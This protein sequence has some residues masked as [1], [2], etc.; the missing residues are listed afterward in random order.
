MLGLKSRVRISAE[1]EEKIVKLAL[2]NSYDK[3]SNY[4]DEFTVSTI[5]HTAWRNIMLRVSNSIYIEHE[6]TEFDT[7]LKKIKKIKSGF[8]ERGSDIHLSI[9]PI[10]K[11]DKF[12]RKYNKKRIVA[13]II[14]KPHNG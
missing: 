8:K 7:I 9:A 14:G 11:I 5:S 1:F 12:G 3:A 13:F 2:D 6:E 4:I 10:K